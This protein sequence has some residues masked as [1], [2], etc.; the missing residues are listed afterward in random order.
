MNYG[1]EWVPVAQNR[2]A[3]LWVNAPD[4][5]AVAA[6]ADAIDARL[7]RDPY[8][9]S[10]SRTGSVRVTFEPPL[11]VQYDVDDAGRRVTVLWV[12]SFQ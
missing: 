4:R 1:V 3:A 2:L 5:A 11:G 9:N 10:E 8:A 12:W 6:A 7:A